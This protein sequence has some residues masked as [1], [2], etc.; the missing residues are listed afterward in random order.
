MNLQIIAM[1]KLTLLLALLFGLGFAFQSCDNTKTYA[2]MQE[3]EDDAIDAFLKEHNIKVISQMEFFDND[4]TTDVA[5]NEYVHLSS[6]VYMQIVDKGS[7]NP[8][9]TVKNNDLILVRFLEYNIQ[10]GDTTLSNLENPSVVDEFKYTVTANSIAGL[11]TQGY[12][13]ASYG[14]QVPAGWLVPF[15][16]IRDK[17]HVRLILPHKMGH[18]TAVQYV[19]PYYYD[20]RKFQIWE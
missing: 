9:D 14:S 16:Y 10:D 12:M 2:E 8:A 11:F 19:T 15:P 20:I 1:K 4:S 6:D 5:Q 7:D 3:E 17:A 18:S 13:Y